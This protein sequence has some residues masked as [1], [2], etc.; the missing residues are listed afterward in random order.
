MIEYKRGFDYSAPIYTDN[1]RF[2]QDIPEVN[3]HFEE[4]ERE[5][6]QFPRVDG[7]IRSTEVVDFVDC[8]VCDSDQNHQLF[9]KFG[10]IYAKCALCSQVFV[11][12]RL[13]NEIL[14]KMYESSI[15][16][17][18]DRK[19]QQSPQHNEY[20]SRIYAKYL[21]YVDGFSIANHSLLD[22]GCGAGEFLQFCADNT[23]YVLHASDFADD[24]FDR[25]CD[26]TKDGRYYHRQKIE[27]VE[28]GDRRFGLITLW[29]VLE[30]IPN[31]V[32]VLRSC[33]TILDE[34]GCILILIPNFHSRAAK[35]LG[36]NTPTL[37]PRA[38]VNF[39]TERSMRHL[40]RRVGLEVKALFQELP[41]IDLMY[42]YIE[43][44]KDLWDGIIDSGEGYYH[45]YVLRR[46]G[47]GSGPWDEPV[48]RARQ[49]GSPQR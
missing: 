45:V 9:V 33:A 3:K 6:A 39:Y 44:N 7:V 49:D 25:I 38:H 34:S 2:R 22:V 35:I 19:V 46:P 20:Y 8:P 40:C 14:L 4:A 17:Q 27:D 23:D 5:M 41:V 32:E 30:H 16:D 42:E 36:V 13:K 1:R 26:L 24:T 12:N 11:R 43:F 29:G 18:L 47:S 10:L 21:S 48:Q 28:F 15:V 31:P 37:N